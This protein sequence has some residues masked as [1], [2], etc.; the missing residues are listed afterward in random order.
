MEYNVEGNPGQGN[1]FQESV[2]SHVDNY[3][4]HA[5]I[6]TSNSSMHEPLDDTADAAQ[7]ATS[8]DPVTIDLSHKHVVR[9]E[10]GTTHIY[11]DTVN[12]HMSFCNLV[13]PCF[14]PRCIILKICRL[15][16]RLKDRM[17][18]HFITH[19]STDTPSVSPPTTN[20]PIDP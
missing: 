1:T 9:K 11:I 3:F 14:R 5:H 16:M 4:Q 6:Y 15:F 12:V 8:S 2:I 7:T 17:I 18:H 19:P 13:L 10:D 20:L